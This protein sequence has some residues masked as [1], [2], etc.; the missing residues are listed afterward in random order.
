[1]RDLWDLPV[2]DATDAAVAALGRT[3]LAYGGFQTA[4]GDHLKATLAEAPDLPLGR[5]TRGSFLMLFGRLDLQGKAASDLAAVRADLPPREAV[6]RAGLE[7]W[8]AGR[9]ESAAAVYQSHLAAHPRDFLAVKLL[10]YLLFYLGDG[11]AMAAASSATFPSWDESVPGSA[12]IH[13]CRAFD[14]EEAGERDDAERIGRAAVAREPRDIWGTHAVAHVMEMQGRAAEGI[15]WLEGL[16]QNW[17]GINPFIGHVWWH[18]A[19]FHLTLGQL[20]AALALHDGAVAGADS[21]ETLDLANA[22]SLLWR[23]ERRGVAIGDRW[24]PLIT[25]ARRRAAEQLLP[26]LDLHLALG[27]ASGGAREDLAQL[28]QRIDAKA[29]DASTTSG[30]VHAAV[31]RTVVAALTA[32]AEGDRQTGVSLLVP[33]LRQLDQ[34]GGSHAQR[35]VF[36]QVAGPSAYGA[37]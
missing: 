17:I 12:F 34:I 2:A 21:D 20:D 11:A 36:W 6:Y 16:E 29:A 33:A 5:L 18:K 24:E 7:H 9:F 35:D 26:F 37:S 31:G 23:L 32:M 8:I 1:M 19:L 27:F 15:A 4:A 28:R 22:I 13:G 30:R 14:L 25:R 10:Q 3:W